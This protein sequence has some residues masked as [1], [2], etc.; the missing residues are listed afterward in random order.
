[1][2][3]PAK[4]KA[5]ALAVLGAAGIIAVLLSGP[6]PQDLAY[7]ELADR[8]ALFGLPN[9]LNVFSNLAFL[10]VGVR[11]LQLWRARGLAIDRRQSLACAWFFVGISLTAF[12]SGWY[13]LEPN[14]S[15]LFWDRLA[16][17]IAFMALSVLVIADHLSVRAAQAL[18]WPLLLLGLGSVI[19]WHLTEQAGRGDLRFYALVQFLPMLLLPLVVLLYRAAWTHAGHYWGVFACYVLAKLCEASDQ[20]LF[21]ATGGLVSGHTL[22]HLAAA[23]GAGWF[24]WMLQRRKA[25]D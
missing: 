9:A 7:H 21:Q 11:G 2:E 6:F 12:G 17:A 22:K 18:L 23:G 20:G 4:S 1:M 8:R 3:H 15:S 10:L 5:L 25:R 16:M 14:N 19:W 24:L 13:H